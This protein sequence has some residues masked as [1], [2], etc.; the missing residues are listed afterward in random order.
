MKVRRFLSYK[1]IYLPSGKVIGLSILSRTFS[2]VAR[3]VWESAEEFHK[4][5]SLENKRRR[6]DW[7]KCE[8]HN[9]PILTGKHKPCRRFWVKE[10]IAALRK[11]ITRLEKRVMSVA[12]DLECE[13]C[14]P[15]PFEEFMQIDWGRSYL[16]SG[17]YVDIDERSKK[18]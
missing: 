2:E 5:V 11:K 13:F 18:A 12:Y 6:E 15:P 3:L 10:E 7:A 16:L 17:S 9:M 1:I 8:F 4:N 14:G